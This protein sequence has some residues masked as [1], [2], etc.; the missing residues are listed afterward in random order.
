VA[1]LQLVGATLTADQRAFATGKLQPLEAALRAGRGVGIRVAESDWPGSAFLT[2]KVV[3]V[4]DDWHVLS[5]RARRSTSRW[6][7]L[8]LADESVAVSSGWPNHDVQELVYACMLASRCTDPGKISEKQREALEFSLGQFFDAQTP[9]GRWPLSR[10]LFFYPKFGNAYCY[11]Y[12]VL[13]HLLGEETLNH[14]LHKYMRCLRAAANSLDDT[15]QQLPGRRVEE[16]F[17]WSTGHLKREDPSP[18]SW[19]TASAYHYCFRLNRLVAEVVRRTTFAYANMEYTTLRQGIPLPRLRIDRSTFLDANVVEQSGSTRSLCAILEGSFL[20]PLRNAREF[21]ASSLSFPKRVPTAAILYGPPGTSKTKLA[22]I[23]A[24]K[25]GWPLLRLDPSHLT[26]KG[27]DQLHAE[28]NHVFSM[29]E[30]CEE[31]VVLF[32]EFDELVRHREEGSESLSRFLTTAMLPKLTALSDRRRIVYLLATNHVEQFD[33]AIS[34]RG[35]FD[36]IIPVMP[37]TF[38]AKISKWPE[39][40][41][42][43]EDVGLAIGSNQ[44]MSPRQ[45]IADLTFDECDDLRKRVE[46]ATTMHEVTRELNAANAK[47]T[48]RQP[49]KVWPGKADGSE[50]DKPIPTWKDTLKEQRTNIRIPDRVG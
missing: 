4:L 28:T 19:S 2:Y 1:D 15:K 9:R 8:R 5:D 21:S 44:E 46:S 42:R 13:T 48:L 41:V 43:I 32:D 39:M 37:P 24:Q 14:L 12:E 30:A 47:C 45:I 23:V 3:K 27:M 38:R 31:V 49:M 16:V 29:L 25:L 33:P 35:R 10:P 6:A 20:R 17:A 34:R 40:L 18:E 7:W 36:M 50:P 26:R 11:D 22:S